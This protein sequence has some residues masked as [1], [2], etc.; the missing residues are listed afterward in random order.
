MPVDKESICKKSSDFHF[1]NDYLYK[2]IDDGSGLN[3]SS[4]YADRYYPEGYEHG[5]PFD[6]DKVTKPLNPRYQAL[7]RRQGP[8]TIQPQQPYRTY[9]SANERKVSLFKFIS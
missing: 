8:V 4:L 6:M 5:A 1:V 9:N 7:N 2:T 3:S